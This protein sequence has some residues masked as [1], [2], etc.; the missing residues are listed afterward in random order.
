[1]LAIESGILAVR[2]IQPLEEAVNRPFLDL[3]EASERTIRTLRVYNDPSHER[4]ILIEFTDGTAI[5][6]EVAPSISM[7]A[8]HYRESNGSLDILHEHKR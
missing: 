8:K 5:S 1:M 7:H 2:Y 4:E 3:P 6:I